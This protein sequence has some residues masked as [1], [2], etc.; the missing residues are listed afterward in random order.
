MCPPGL[1]SGDLTEPYPNT[2]NLA[3]LKKWADEAHLD[4]NDPRNTKFLSLLQ[5]VPTTTTT[6]AEVHRPVF[7]LR[8][9][10]E[11]ERFVSD[12]EF[13]KERRFALLEHRQQGHPEL[14]NKCIPMAKEHIS[15]SQWKA[16]Q[17]YQAYKD[18]ELPPTYQGDFHGN[19]REERNRFLLQIREQV[20]SRVRSGRA[21]LKLDDVIHYDIIPN[22]SGLKATLLELISPRR[23]LKPRR[24]P[25]RKAKAQ[26]QQISEANIV[27]RI[28]RAFGVPLR[29]HHPS[30]EHSHRRG[31]SLSVS[32]P[33]GHTPTL[34]SSHPPPHHHH[35]DEDMITGAP[36]AIRSTVCPFVEVSVTHSDVCQRTSTAA[37]PNPYWNEELTIPFHPPFGD[38]SPSNLAKVTDSIQFNLFDEI[39][40]DLLQDDRERGTNI[41]QRREKRWLGSFTLPFSTL[42]ARTRIEG[43]FVLE[44]PKLLLGYSTSSAPLD[45]THYGQGHTH[46]G[47]G[48]SH[49]QLFISLEPPLSSLPPIRDIFSSTEEPHLLRRAS[50]WL[51]NLYDDHPERQFLAT[52]LDSTGHRVIVSRYIHPQ[53]PPVEICPAGDTNQ[54][55]A[56]ELLAHYVSLIP[57]LPDAI[58]F[59]G[60]CDIWTTSDQFLH[61]LAGDEEEHAVLLTNYFLHCGWQAWLVLG[62]GIPEGDSNTLPAISSHLNHDSASWGP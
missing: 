52:V 47:S 38:F 59:S 57:F 40:I 44:V 36:P 48:C 30:E 11:K 41:H 26:N 35:D 53:S 58:T 21:Q 34:T 12:E 32:P 43:T 16:V 28:V 9:L 54:Q 29:H 51:R 1:E 7:R 24:K 31:R 15:A 50:Q 13:A 39:T 62:H 5:S 23:P 45:H 55:Q 2:A 20:L 4:P 27:V 42:H 37:G 18:Y 6:G 25:A 8:Q 46:Q 17:E 56:M 3:S 61:M 49:L 33:R 19:R 22:I 60:E 10:H 14:K